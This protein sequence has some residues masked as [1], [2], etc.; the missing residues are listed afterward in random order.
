MQA[1]QST[2]AA[3]T[4]KARGVPPA[5]YNDLA[6]YF[7][8]V[9]YKVLQWKYKLSVEKYCTRQCMFD[10]KSGYSIFELKLL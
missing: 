5:R 8:T 1:I 3:I 9:K 6:D 7:Y 2:D 4:A 10:I